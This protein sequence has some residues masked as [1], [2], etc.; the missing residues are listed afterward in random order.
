MRADK[1]RAGV[2]RKHAVALI[3]QFTLA[4]LRALRAPLRVRSQLFIALIASVDRQKK[5]ARVGRVKHHGEAQVGCLFKQRREP[6]VIDAQQ[7]ACGVANMQAKVFPELDADR[8]MVGKP[9]QPVQ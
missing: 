2:A 8:P 1:Q 5:R 4:V 7:L 9:L 6:L 3:E